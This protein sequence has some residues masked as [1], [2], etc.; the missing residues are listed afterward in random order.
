MR[1]GGARERLGLRL[2]RWRARDR[3][4]HVVT[5]DINQDKKPDVWKFFK[6]VDIG[7]QKTQKT[8]ALY[9]STVLLLPNSFFGPFEAVAAKRTQLVVGLDP[10]PERLPSEF[11]DEEPAAACSRFCRGIV[12]AVASTA[13]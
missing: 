10:V 4:K 6:T 13:G 12:A 9:A 5:A 1:A 2:L 3:D 7:G 8:D 11:R